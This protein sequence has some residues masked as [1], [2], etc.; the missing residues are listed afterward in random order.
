M[1]SGNQVPYLDLVER[2]LPGLV[3]DLSG[4][5]GEERPGVAAR[6]AVPGVATDKDA[7]LARSDQLLRF[8]DGTNQEL[9]YESF[10]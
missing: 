5:G 3:E 4:D 10:S 9:W 2:G 6:V 8:R 1:P 7:G